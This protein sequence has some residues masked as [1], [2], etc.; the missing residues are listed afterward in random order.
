M[1]S[2]V[3]ELTRHDFE[4]GY[5]AVVHALALNIYATWTAVLCG[6]PT[7]KQKEIYER[8]K[9]MQ[10]GDLVL[11]VSSMVRRREWP[12]LGIGIL[13]EIEQVPYY[14][15]KQWRMAC[16]EEQREYERLKIKYPPDGQPPDAWSYDWLRWKN[17]PR[18]HTDPIP[19]EAV[20][21]IEPLLGEENETARWENARFIAGWLDFP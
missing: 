7:P 19:T 17:G 6:D 14:T 11:E 4:A 15:R 10:P 9:D 18:Q 21:V 5:E 1:A 16:R 13:R 2:S 8:M 12:G 3:E 20:Y